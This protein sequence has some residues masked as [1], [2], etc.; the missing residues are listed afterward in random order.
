MNK[1]A[2]LELAEFI[3]GIPHLDPAES[4]SGLQVKAPLGKWFRMDIWMTRTV[5]NLGCGTVGCIAGLAADHWDMPME[6]TKIGEVMGLTSAQSMDLFTPDRTYG[7]GYRGITP[8]MAG[9]VLRHLAETGE[10]DWRVIAHCQVCGNH[11][12]QGWHGQCGE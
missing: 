12:N 2:I 9:T 10:V 5:Y 8:A 7:V 6:S 11:L 4:F 3:E 1:E